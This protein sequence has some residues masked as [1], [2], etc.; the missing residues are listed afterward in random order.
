M[1]W[2]VYVKG[3]EGG[4]YTIILQQ[5]PE[6]D[7]I[8]NNI[9]PFTIYNNIIIYY[10][11]QNVTIK[12]LKQQIKTKCGIKVDQQRLIYAGQELRDNDTIADYPSIRHNSTLFLVLRL[13]GGAIR[14]PP[15]GIP[16]LQQPCLRCNT[17]PSLSLPCSDTYCATC[18]FQYAME[19]T[20]DNDK[21]K[22]HIQC[23]TCNDTWSIDVIQRY[24][25][26]DPEEV[27]VLA[28]KLSE[29]TIRLSDTIFVCPACGTNCE[30]DVR[31]TRVHCIMCKKGKRPAD[32]CW[33]CKQSWVNQRSTTNC[34]NDKCRH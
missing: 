4:T 31:V 17:P 11:I 8:C 2:T 25:G 19:E 23:P 1:A 20:T 7:S 34:G 28:T 6:V 29:N 27:N 12:Y 22:P 14:P 24:T 26:A 21:L 32:F 10:I 30:R 13:P 5:P 15:P 3:I 9:R 16:L 18:I 33:N